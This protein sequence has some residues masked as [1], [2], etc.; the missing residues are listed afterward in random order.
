MTEFDWVEGRLTQRNVY[1][2]E[3]ELF[4]CG[5]AIL[6]IYRYSAVERVV[7]PSSREVI[8]FAE[9]HIDSVGIDSLLSQLHWQEGDRVRCVDGVYQL[10]D[11]QLYRGCASAFKL[12]AEPTGSRDCFL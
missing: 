10:A 7:V 2:F 12:P 3:G 4:Y 6:P 8:A 1:Q 9:S 11:I 5:L